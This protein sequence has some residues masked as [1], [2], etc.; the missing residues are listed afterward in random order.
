M[1]L[2]NKLRIFAVTLII[3]FYAMD[4]QLPSQLVF[5][6]DSQSLQS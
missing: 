5:A 3:S 6:E 1:Y 2:I 4:T